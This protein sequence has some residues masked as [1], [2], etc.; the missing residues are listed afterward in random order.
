MSSETRDPYRIADVF[1]PIAIDDGLDD[2]QIEQEWLDD[3]IDQDQ[4]ARVKSVEARNRVRRYLAFNGAAVWGRVDR[5]LAAADRDRTMHPAASI[6]A[7]TTAAE[8]TIRFLLLRPLIAGFV[9]HTKL[10]MRL[11]REG[12]T[13]RTDLDRRLLP[14]VC[15]AWGFDIEARQLP[16]GQPLWASI[17]SLTEVRNR[18][19]HRADPVAAEQA[20]GAVDCATSLIDNIVKPMAAQ[21]NLGWPPTDW[22]HNGR[23]HDPVDA[24][25]D[26]MGS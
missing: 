26:F 11:V 24:T 13:G 1:P 23:T 9:F 20:A 12:Y 15:R 14:D 4:I 8:L 5:S 6:V 22:S 2:W 3:E 10:A 21:L 18:Y 17:G 25:I 19:V 7:A 16:N